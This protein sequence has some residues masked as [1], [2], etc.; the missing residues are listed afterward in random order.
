[1]MITYIHTYRKRWTKKLCTHNGVLAWTNRFQMKR[2]RETD[3]GSRDSVALSQ[4]FLIS[5]IPET[6]TS[7]QSIY[8]SAFVKAPGSRQKNRTHIGTDQHRGKRT[9]PS[10]RWLRHRESMRLA[11][12]RLAVVATPS[13]PPPSRWPSAPAFAALNSHSP[14]DG[15][16]LPGAQKSRGRT[17][18]RQ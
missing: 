9:F 4:D 1:M 3:S 17:A 7:N 5:R 12:Q 15:G 8:A 18:G 16:R 6:T 11:C 10:S 2:R 13:R 14:S